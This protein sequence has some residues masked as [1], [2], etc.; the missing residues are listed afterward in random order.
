MMVTRFG[1][2][3]SLGPVTYGRTYAARFLDGSDMEEK[4]YSEE[5]ARRIDAEVR[6]ILDA[7]M[8]RAR[9]LIDE[10]R[11]ALEAIAH[12][13]LEV[14][15]LDRP[16]LEALVG[17]HRPAAGD[18]M[19]HLARLR[20]MRQK[21]LEGGG[22]QR[23]DDQHARG[24]KTARE[25]LALLL[26]EGTFQ[27]IGALATHD[28]TEFG[29]E[30]Q[31][32]PGDGVVCG[33]GKVNGRRVAVFAHDFTVLGGSFSTVQSQKICRLQDL[34]L[35]SGVPLIGL[36][37][38]GGARIQEGVQE[39]GGL[40]RGLHP[41]RPR[42]GSRPADLGDPRPLRR[43]GRLL[44]GPH[45]LRHHDGEDEP[46]V[47]HRPRRDQGRHRRGGE[48]P[49][50]RRQCGPQ[51]SQRSRA[52]SRRERVPGPRDRQAPPRLPASEQ[53]RGPAAGRRPTTRPDRMDEAL[54]HLI[55]RERQRA[56]RHA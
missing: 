16:E 21:A 11:D 42:L 6:S 4:N 56:L 43:G 17:T 26:D 28:C 30:K 48:R 55:P 3:E 23:I 27:E 52:A 37:D 31:R 35:S 24:K 32:Y 44:A 9:K 40:R 12:R 50:P 38:S 19:T 49:R 34:A 14:E 46:H 51:R 13:L 15:T 29:M 45:R 41:Q 22:A 5:T 47:H 20:E 54:N 36:N 53:H 39:P 8:D 1:M 7:Q 18:R 33:F 2:T 10:R 25:R